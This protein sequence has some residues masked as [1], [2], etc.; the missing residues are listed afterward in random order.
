[1]APVE[2]R[3]EMSLAEVIQTDWKP[4]KPAGRGRGAANGAANGAGRGGAKAGRRGAAGRGGKGQGRKAAPPARLRNGTLGVR[5]TIG[6]K[7]GG[8][9][10][11]VAGRG[12]GR[13]KARG[14]GQQPQQQRQQRGGGY[15]AAVLQRSSGGR[16]RGLQ[17]WRGV[18]AMQG[19]G[20]GYGRSKGAGKAGGKGAG[21]AG[22]GPGW[23]KG[24]GKGWSKAGQMSLGPPVSRKGGIQKLWRGAKGA[25]WGKGKSPLG[26]KGAY[27]K[28]YAKGLAAAAGKKGGGAKGYGWKGGK[29]G[30]GVRSM[31]MKGGK[32]KGSMKGDWQHD[33]F[34]GPDFGDGAD[35]E[36]AWS[37]ARGA[38]K[39]KAKGYAKGKGKGSMRGF[40]D[41]YDGGAGYRPGTVDADQTLSNED[42]KMMKKITIV[43]QLDKV[44]KPPPAMQGLALNKGG[45]RSSSPRDSGAL[46]SRFGANFDR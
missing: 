14:R 2:D 18:S 16:G 15:A 45:K 41:D 1:M 32:G 6:P 4:Q 26:M 35:M 20:K 11:Q 7:N 30:K 13:G 29:N 27:D 28:G 21:W 43:A 25:G 31:M 17:L 39:G 36:D 24:K 10:Q 23:G 22:K 40:S 44:P 46:S 38:S 9:S 12:R 37:R 34:D 5:R 33:M 42:R 19:R 3:L 8:N